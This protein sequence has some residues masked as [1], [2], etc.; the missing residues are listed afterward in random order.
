MTRKYNPNYEGSY[1]TYKYYTYSDIIYVH[2][3]ITQLLSSLLLQVRIVYVVYD[4]CVCVVEVPMITRELKR[5]SYH[6]V[7]TRI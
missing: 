5:S 4:V 7:M 3:H 1:T 6:F 2:T